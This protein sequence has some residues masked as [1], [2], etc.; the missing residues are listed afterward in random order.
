MGYSQISFYLNK[1]YF[2]KVLGNRS[3][4]KFNDEKP[5]NRVTKMP[6]SKVIKEVKIEVAST[7]Y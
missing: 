2:K 7:P 6:T 4:I 3:M 1:N 5:S